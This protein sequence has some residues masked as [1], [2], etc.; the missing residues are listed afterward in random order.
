MQTQRP[1]LGAALAAAAVGFAG[2]VLESVFVAFLHGYYFHTVRSYLAFVLAPGAVYAVAGL[3]LGAFVAWLLSVIRKG[4]RPAPAVAGAAAFVLVALVATATIED[5]ELAGRA[6]F[7]WG[8]AGL[9]LAIILGGALWLA[10]HRARRTPDVAAIVVVPALAVALGSGLWLFGPGG[11]GNSRVAAEASEEPVSVLLVTIDTLRSD[12]VGCFAGQDSASLTPTIDGLAARG[13]RFENAVVPI[14]VTDPSHASIL[15][16][17][18]PAEHGVVRN[19]VP[20]RPSVVTVAEVFAAAGYR[21]GAAISVSHMDAHP[22]GLS[23]GFEI[24]FDRGAHD[25][26]R[27]H[28]GWKTLPQPT[29]GRVFAHERSGVETNE[30]AVRFLD[31]L[32]DGPFFLWVH[33]FEP[34]TPYVGDDG[35]VFDEEERATLERAASRGGAEEMA[36][37]IVGLYED[38]VRRADRALGELLGAVEERGLLDATAVVIVAD[39]GEHM[40]EER[41]EPAFWFGHSDV[42]DETCRVPLVVA[43]P[44]HGEAVSVTEQVSTMRLAG[45]L[46]EMAGVAADWPHGALGRPAGPV[47]EPLVVESNPHMPVEGA[48]LRA[49]WWKLIERPGGARELYDLRNDRHERH[50]IV[51]A[52][53]ALADSLERAMA[54]IV[55]EWGPVEDPA[56]PDRATREMLR[57][58]G[59]LE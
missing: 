6:M 7:V 52:R 59:Y 44:G 40:D 17:L 42:Y 56:E 49:G 29:K 27:Y 10:T 38:E 15:T 28:A 25:R 37:E 53:P 14:V 8:T 41:L 24:Y 2:G 39:H 1:V 32:S 47:A 22:S 54:R 34:H 26:F 23:Q 9:T 13:I 4:F 11:S 55:Q 31:D 43:P 46:L 35:A 58:L 16:G 36:R 5:A 50:N 33:Y 18:Y 3:A 19:A 57:S 20:L 51:D 45:T 12:R 48:A 30:R 21:T